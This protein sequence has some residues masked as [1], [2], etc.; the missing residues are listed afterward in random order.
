MPPWYP[1]WYP[2]GTQN[3]EWY[4]NGTQDGTQ[5]VPKLPDTFYCM[6]NFHHFEGPKNGPEASLTI[7]LGTIVNSWVPLM[8]FSENISYQLL[9]NKNGAVNSPYLLT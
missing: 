9:R 2:N 4:P 6:I 3:V 1:K 5:V 8:I 7:I